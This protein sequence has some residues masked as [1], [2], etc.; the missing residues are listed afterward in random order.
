[1]RVAEAFSSVGCHLMLASLYVSSICGFCSLRDG[2]GPRR[3]PI[4]NPMAAVVCD[5]KKSLQMGAKIRWVIGNPGLEW[6]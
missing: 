5:R 2:R 3:L 4:S 6:P 1:M